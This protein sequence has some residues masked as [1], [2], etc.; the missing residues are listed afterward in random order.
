MNCPVCPNANIPPEQTSC[1]NCGADL[2]PIRRL[3]ELPARWYNEALALLRDGDAGAAIVRLHSAAA[4]DPDAPHIRR[5]LGKA[6]WNARRSAEA[7]AQWRMLPDDEESRRLLAM[8][9]PTS[10]RRRAMSVPVLLLSILIVL[11]GLGA[12]LFNNRRPE[13]PPLRE[14]SVSQ[15]SVTQVAMPKPAAGSAHLASL[16]ER[17]RGHGE[18]RAE[19]RGGVLTITFSDGLFPS[20]SDVPTRAGQTMLRSIARELAATS[21]PM[22]VIVEGFTDSNPP[23]QD[24]R[25]SDNW[26]LAFSR[27]YAAVELMRRDAG[28]AVSWSARSAGDIGTPYANDGD[29]SRARNRTVVLHVE[30]RSGP[31]S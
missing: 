27:A 9:P 2:T 21:A 28:G 7:I 20:G 24:G 8:S 25:W 3:Q 26:S 22:L 30:E 5:L 13:R 19:R 10:E 6:L 23:P 12:M 4:I 16:A 31:I 17:L 18:L 11:A 14:P 29:T 1:S 15:P